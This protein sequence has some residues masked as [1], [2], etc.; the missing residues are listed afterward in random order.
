MAPSWVSVV[1]RPQHYDEGTLT[2]EILEYQIID[3]AER[4]GSGIA[5]C[6]ADGEDGGRHLL[7]LHVVGAS[8]NGVLENIEMKGNPAYYYLCNKATG[9]AK[10]VK[11]N[12]HGW[13]QP[14][15]YLRELV[16]QDLDQV[17][18]IPKRNV[19]LV[20]LGKVAKKYNYDIGMPVKKA[21]GGKAVAGKKSSK[22]KKVGAGDKDKDKD[23]EKDKDKQKGK[24]RV[25]ADKTDGRKAVVFSDSE[26]DRSHG[27]SDVD[28][29]SY[30]PKRVDARSGLG[31]DLRQLRDDLLEGHGKTQRAGEGE[32]VRRVEGGDRRRDAGQG[33][34]QA[35][36]KHAEEDRGKGGSA[37]GPAPKSRPEVKEVRTCAFGSS[38]VARDLRRRRKSDGY[39]GSRKRAATEDDE[40]D[41]GDHEASDDSSASAFFRDASSSTGRLSRMRLV[42]VAERH[43][44]RLAE[45]CSRRMFR[46]VMVEGEA[47]DEW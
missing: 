18:W 23:K 17:S 13:I 20:L 38:Y 28:E 26:P 30:H 5:L 10:A 6:V 1:R 45:R 44:G 22:A 29:D 36:P 43:P 3:D 46:K 25:S 41:E 33:L 39:V 12:K 42:H 24:E 7:E 31:K 47:T 19:L 35:Q 8:D 37:T 27:A 34:E 21:N 11:H 32:R 2:A 9:D 14:I 4:R 40:R 16:F 15:C